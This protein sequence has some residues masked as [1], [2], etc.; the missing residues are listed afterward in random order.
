MEL[1]E[2]APPEAASPSAV[3]WNALSERCR[4]RLPLAYSVFL[5]QCAGIS[6]ADGVLTLYGPDSVLKRLNNERVL[7]VLQE[8][9]GA[10]RV[11]MREGEPPPA[12]PQD[13][14]RDLLNFSRQRPDIIRIIGD[15]PLSRENNQ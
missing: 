6:F 11:I 12:S 3:T 14:Q 13:N 5:N 8:E 7:P 1:E 4:E 9:S 15:K 10:E 2:D